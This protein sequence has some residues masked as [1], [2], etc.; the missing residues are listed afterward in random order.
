MKIFGK[1]TSREEIHQKTGDISQLGGIKY[2]EMIDGVSRGVRGIDIKSPCGLDMTIL[3]DRGMDIS[4]LSYMS[5]PIAWRSATRETSNAYYESSGLE[6]LRTFFGGLVTTCGLTYMG[7]PDIDEG[8]ELGLHGR[9]SNISA[10]NVLADG[11]WEGD[12]YKMWVQGKV[13]EAKVF[14]DKLELER[15]I[16]T[17]MDQP[18]VILEDVVENIGSQTSPLMVLYH[19]N[20]GYPV[21][22]QGAVLLEPEAKVTARDKEAEKGIENYSRFGEPIKNYSEQVFFHEIGADDEGNG[23]IAIANEAFSNGK[24]IGIWLKYNKDNL[25]CLTQWKQMGMGEYV[26]GIEPGN[27]Y[28]R[29]RSIEKKEN[30][31]RYIEPGERVNFRLEF[32]ILKSNKDIAAF[33]KTYM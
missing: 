25:P 1:E 10:E 29:G 18:R 5:T 7:A 21:V 22:D 31:I 32:N 3:P 28:P 27:S 9:I 33:K 24:G 15:K 4:N 20:I 2:Y 14:G 19:V 17:W 8:E 26:C 12:S 23:N 13:R 6:W 11:K 30:N 16:T